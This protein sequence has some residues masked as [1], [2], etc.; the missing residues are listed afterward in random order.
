V[1]PSGGRGG[2][3]GGEADQAA[4]I[5]QKKSVVRLWRGEPSR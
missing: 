2:F 1:R 4:E 3:L 5:E